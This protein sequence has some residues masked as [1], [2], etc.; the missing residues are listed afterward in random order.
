V[1]Y[2][3]QDSRPIEGK[4]TQA[5]RNGRVEMDDVRIQLVLKLSQVLDALP[6]AQWSELAHFVQLYEIYS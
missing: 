2:R 4:A 3:N 6:Y 1:A 5:A